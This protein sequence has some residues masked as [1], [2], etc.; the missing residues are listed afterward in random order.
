M[1]RN[2]PSYSRNSAPYILDNLT[3]FPSSHICSR[4]QYQF[5][6][7]QTNGLLGFAHF[8]TTVF[9]LLKIS[10]SSNNL[11][12]QPQK[13]S[14]NLLLF[15]EIKLCTMQIQNEV[16]SQSPALLS[17]GGRLA[18]PPGGGPASIIS[19]SND[20]AWCKRPIF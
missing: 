20:S 8:G 18:K 9:T 19:L 3:L 17:G 15:S 6:N 13:S 12:E 16:R 7:T 5:T 4:L 1:D 2:I 11:L 14:S 10:E